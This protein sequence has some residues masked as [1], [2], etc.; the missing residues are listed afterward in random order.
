MRA[1]LIIYIIR[2]IRQK[3]KYYVFIDKAGKLTAVELKAGETVSADFFS[4]LAYFSSLQTGKLE[5]FL[6]YGRN[7][8]HIRSN[9]TLVKPWDVLT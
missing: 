3:T 8:E 5:K 4:G 7:Q 9:G 6:V 2:A 1:Q